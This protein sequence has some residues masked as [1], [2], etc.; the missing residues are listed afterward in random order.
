MAPSQWKTGLWTLTLL[1]ASAGC[2]SETEVS[3]NTLRARFDGTWRSFDSHRTVNL[4]SLPDSNDLYLS[5]RAEPEVSR[6]GVP[7][8]P[9]SYGIGVT[10]RDFDVG[11]GP[12][13]FPIEHSLDT[14]DNHRRGPRI[15]HGPGHDD[16]IHGVQLR[17][18]C[19]G[20]GIRPDAI[21]SIRGRFLLEESTGTRLVGRL[22]L[23]VTSEE[24]GHCG[25][26]AAEID[27]PIDVERGALAPGH[28]NPTP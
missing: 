24:G 16:Q 9:T 20:P 10:M 4:A 25:E 22:V 6:P 14:P 27:L 28:L 12:S 13:T 7:L 5:I 18:H 15:H 21:Q 11:V 26:D 8:E 19:V 23:N 3:T 1:A 17:A 2:G